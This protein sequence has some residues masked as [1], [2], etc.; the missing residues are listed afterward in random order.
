VE[1]GHQVPAKPTE[2][3]R[4]YALGAIADERAEVLLNS[5]LRLLLALG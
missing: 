1:S 3:S 5:S 4:Q 2:L